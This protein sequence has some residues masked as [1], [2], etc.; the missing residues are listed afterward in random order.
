MALALVAALSCAEAAQAN[1]TTNGG[2]PGRANSSMGTHAQAPFERLWTTKPTRA[3][4]TWCTPTKRCG[5]L[6]EFG[7]VVGDGRVYGTTVGGTTFALSVDTGE[8]LWR[9]NLRRTWAT[10][11]TFYRGHLYLN[12]PQRRA[13]K[14]PAR[15]SL[16]KLDASTGRTV[17]RRPLHPRIWLRTEGPPLVV[18]GRVY[19]TANKPDTKTSRVVAFDI[20]G[21]RLW[22]RAMCGLSWQSP[23][24]TGRY[25][26]AA[27]Y[28]GNVR[29]YRPRTGGVA[30]QRNLGPWNI[31][32]QTASV[33][34]RL[35]VFPKSG[36]VWA[37][38][39]TNGRTVWASRAV[40]GLAYSDCAANRQKVWCAGLDGRVAA[41]AAKNGQLIWR[42][43]FPSQ[44]YGGLVATRYHLWVALHDRREI[45]ALWRGTGRVAYRHPTGRYDPA[46]PVGD[47]VYVSGFRNVTKLRSAEA[48]RRPSE[49][50]RLRVGG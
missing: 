27:D 38:R 34:Q 15:G 2:G 37:L 23:T 29:A 44:I 39:A 36:V 41:L 21:R 46:A 32:A 22:S 45:V 19:V 3:K 50:S 48:V 14:A 25:V 1:W 9:R 30:W 31:Y 11:P 47:T 42:R 7:V 18:R 8:V 5:P 6:L 13:D 17:W 16:F 10:I 40:Y 24:W 33:G 26:V 43:Q 49:Q 20:W 28:C 4:D 12:G 35:Y